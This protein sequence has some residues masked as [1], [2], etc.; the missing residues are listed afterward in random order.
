MRGYA[1]TRNGTYV[2]TAVA[3]LLFVA[4][5][6]IFADGLLVGPLWNAES[7]IDSPLVTWLLL[8]VIVGAGVYQANRIPAGG[9]PLPLP[10]D[11][12]TPGQTDDPRPW[13][14]LTGNVLVALI[15]LPVRFFVGREWFSSGAHKVVDPA[16]MD[17]GA[18]LRGYFERAVA[19][20]EQGRPPITYDWFRSFLQFMLDNGWYS[21]FAGV[22][23]VGEVLVGLG[24]IVGGLVG[25]AAFFG[26]VMNVSFGL[27]GTASSNPILFGLGV[28]LVLAWRV[29]GFWGVDRVLFR[30][31]GI[32]PNP[33]DAAR[34]SE[35]G[36]PLDRRLPAGASD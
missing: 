9:I 31:F 14:L 35:P 17:G 11:E 33:W 13:R 23:A 24:L 1:M 25:L 5:C 18:A 2:L 6:W 19:I 16:W 27:A 20:P 34:L 15:W 3:A 21:W 26:T 10:A 29:A 12:A 7:W 8:A 28:L 22:V 36:R 32:R 30:V 4:L